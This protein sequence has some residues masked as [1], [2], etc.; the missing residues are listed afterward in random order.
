MSD[1]SDSIPATHSPIGNVWRRGLLMLVFAFCLG[2]AKFVFFAVVVFQFITLVITSRANKK[3]L[4]F[5]QELCRYQYQIMRFLTCNSEL[6]PFPIGDWP[7]QALGA[8]EH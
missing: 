3:L 6:L 2:V 7:A 4:K 5:G 1:K 8:D